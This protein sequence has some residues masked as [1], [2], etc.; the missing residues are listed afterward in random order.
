MYLRNSKQ[1]KVMYDYQ[2]FF[3]QS[4]GGISRYFVELA[5]RIAMHESV[6]SKIITPL[7]V[8]QHVREL[9]SGIVS[10]FYIPEFP[11]FAPILKPFIQMLSSHMLNQF[12]PDILHETYYSEKPLIAGKRVKTVVTVHDMIHERFPD[13]F[14]H[15]DTVAQNKSLSVKRADHVIC[16]SEAT[17]QD[18]LEITGISPS[19]VSVVYHGFELGVKVK[20]FNEIGIISKPYLLYVGTRGGYKNFTQ[21]LKAYG[22]NSI[23]NKEY[24]IVCFGG[25]EKTQ[26]EQDIMKELGLSTDR[27]IWMNGDDLLLAQ[28]YYHAKALVYPSLYEGFG[29][30][31]LESMSYGCPVICSNKGSIPE[32]VGNAAELFDPYDEDAIVYA[33]DQV[34]SN[35]N[36]INTLRTLGKKRIRRFSWSSCAEKTYK[37]YR[38]L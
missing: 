22:N 37:I 3:A 29:L 15:N 10:G 1:M 19:K 30:P 32:V 16:V 20:K 5:S 28:L 31:L 4:Y 26:T 6:D 34:V 25:E 23:L 14:P 17:K 35:P 8:N 12:I 36:R 2:I 11:K 13:Y 18:L 27:I 7:Y 24:K 38:S 21:L 33:I 9:K